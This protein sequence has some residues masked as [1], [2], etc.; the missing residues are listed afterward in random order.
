M[1]SLHLF[2]FV[3]FFSLSFYLSFCVQMKQFKIASEGQI[4]CVNNSVYKKKQEQHLSM[5]T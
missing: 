3:L 1:S 4:L 5:Q 2:T